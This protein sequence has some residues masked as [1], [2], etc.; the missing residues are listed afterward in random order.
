MVNKMH[1]ALE[2]A[3]EHAAALGR[4]LGHWAVLEMLLTVLMQR[5][6]QLG[7]QKAD[8]IFKEIVSLKAKLKLLKRINHHFTID[9]VLKEEIHD[10][11][12][13]AEKLNEDRNKFI[14]SGW[15]GDSRDM[16]RIES[17]LPPSY[18]KLTKSHIKFTPQNIQNFVEKI[19]QLSGFLNDLLF[20]TR[21]VQLTQP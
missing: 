13:S 6:F 12:V 9:G 1:I 17:S 10:L 16:V 2:Q 20:R 11:L 3:P 5:L 21:E 14:H 18:K 15:A 7:P 4:L 8:L 19:A